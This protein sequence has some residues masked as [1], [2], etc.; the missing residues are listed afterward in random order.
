MSGCFSAPWASLLNHWKSFKEVDVISQQ[1]HRRCWAL[2]SIT[3]HACNDICYRSSIRLE[4][5]PSDP[6]ADVWEQRLLAEEHHLCMCVCLCVHGH[7]EP[8]MCRSDACATLAVFQRSSRPFLQQRV[9]HAD[10][11]ELKSRKCSDYT[12]IQYN[13]L[14][15]VMVVP[16]VIQITALL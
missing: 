9:L 3:V 6:W 11:H 8:L 1:L 14:H 15:F 5:R 7:A 2:G 10:W 4:N 16:A 13:D 12:Y